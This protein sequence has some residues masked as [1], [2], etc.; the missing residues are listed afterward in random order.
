MI[1][2]YPNRRVMKWNS[3]CGLK[4]LPLGVYCY[5]GTVAIAQIK[6]YGRCLRW[7][8]IN[9]LMTDVLYFNMLETAHW[10]IKTFLESA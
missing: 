4:S 2:P 8:D 7:G 9:T 6:E 1:Q 5:L 10:V 3:Y